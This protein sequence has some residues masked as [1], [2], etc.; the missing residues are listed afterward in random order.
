MKTALEKLI[1]AV[2]NIEDLLSEG[3]TDTQNE[4]WSREIDE[5]FDALNEAKKEQ[6]K[7]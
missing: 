4:N 7:P 2:E 5:L 3:L 1:A 6:G